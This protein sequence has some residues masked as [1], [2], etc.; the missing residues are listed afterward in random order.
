MG[1]IDLFREAALKKVSS[2]EQ[3]DRLMP[4]TRPRGWVAL[5]ALAAVLAAALGWGIYGAVPTRVGGRG[6]LLEQGGGVIDVQAKNAGRLLS[7]AVQAGDRVDAGQ[8]IAR[9]DQR[10]LALSL[11]QAQGFATELRSQRDQTASF[12]E[13][14]LREQERNLRAQAAGLQQRARD[15][16]ANFRVQRAAIETR[17]RDGAERLKSLEALL[18]VEEDLLRQGY[19]SKLQVQDMR[20]RVESA[21]EEVSKANADL[22]QLETTTKENVAKV[23]TDSEQL[24][25]KLLELQN[26]RSQALDGYALKLV[27]ADQKV[28]QLASDLDESGV[29]LA[30]VAGTVVELVAAP[31]TIVNERSAIVKVETGGRRLEGVVYVPAGT[32]KEV[33]VGTRVEITPATVKKEE[34]GS[35]LGRVKSV[36]ELPSTTSGIMAV[37]DNQD[38]VRTLLASGPQLAIGVELLLDPQARSG[39]RWTS[40]RG[41]DVTITPG[42]LAAA[43]MIVREQPPI[44]LVIPYLKKFFGIS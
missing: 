29:V 41:P 44:T 15:A 33:K 23:R 26:Q 22:R 35:M 7:L 18:T 30:P 38:L 39:F 20:E 40:A 32:G 36:G 14:Y 28:R 24:N 42:T 13:Q 2:P 27:E 43:Q 25:I 10:D 19:V 6:I 5:G 8:L 31:G 1:T 21:R 3:L 12:Y 4:V 17:L 9:I 11:R 34:W 37:L 16:E